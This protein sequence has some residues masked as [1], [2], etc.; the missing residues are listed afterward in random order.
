LIELMVVVLIGA[1]LVGI[2]VPTYSTFV[3]K[4]RRT[5]AK[6]ALLDMA[7]LEERYYSTANA[8]SAT[9]TDVGYP[10]GAW[11]Q[12]VGSAYYQITAPVITAAAV[13]APATYTLTAVPIGDQVKDTSC[14]SFT[15]T[16]KGVQ[17]A[18]DSGGADATA[19]CWR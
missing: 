12:T 1:I 4:S 9:T 11:P 18:L 13:G 19:T 14:A 6:T 8:Y 16:S 3:R 17:S 2:A 10:A 5:E 15:V 7:A